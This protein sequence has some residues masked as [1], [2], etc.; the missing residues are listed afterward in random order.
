LKERKVPSWLSGPLVLGVAGL[1][2]WLERRR[3][4]RRS[5][6]SKSTRE[7]RNLALA[8]VGAVALSLT[9]KPLAEALTS[10]VERRRWGLLKV[11]RLPRSVE[12]ALAIV[13]LDYTL[14]L[15]HVLTHRVPFLWRFHLVHHID[16]DLDASTALRFHFAE[17]VI[18]VPWRAAQILFIGV[19]PLAFS[20][21]QTCLLVSILFHHSNVRLPFEV[22]RRLNRLVV[23][24]RMH[25]IHHS[26]VKEETGSNWSSGL[27]VWDWLHGTLRLDVPQSEIVIGVPAYRDP[28]EVGLAEI[29]KMPFTEERPAWQPRGENTLTA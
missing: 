17:L 10:L 6:E 15:W 27:T 22:E 14:Y 4:L 24:P 26:N 13:L 18:S 9:E 21:W 23:T 11:V 12:V 2:V 5:V 29:L 8:A 28:R 3:P 19:S 16:L 25:G 20:V 1:L 7:A